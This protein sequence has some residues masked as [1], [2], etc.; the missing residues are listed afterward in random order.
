MRNSFSQWCNYAVVSTTLSSGE[1]EEKAIRR[2]AKRRGQNA[3]LKALVALQ[4]L[5][6]IKARLRRGNLRRYTIVR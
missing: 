6:G 4:Q 2:D 5:T 3:P 1:A